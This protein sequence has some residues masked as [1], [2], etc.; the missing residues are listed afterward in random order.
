M[1]LW[2]QDSLVLFNTLCQSLEFSFDGFQDTSRHFPKPCVALASGQPGFIRA[3]C[4]SMEFSFA[5]FQD[6]NWY[7]PKPGEA[8]APEQPC[9]I[10]C[11]MPKPGIQLRRIPGHKPVFTK[12]LCCFGTGTAL[13]YMLSYAKARNS[14]SP[15]SR[16]QAG[17]SQSPVRLWHR[18]SLVLFNTLCQ[19]LEFTFAEF[20][21]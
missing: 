18:N 7:F 20:R 15:D 10:F 8:L 12:A 13:S 2:H 16:P 21:N 14:A 19:S 9:L 5:G 4:Q 11:L 1:L 3:L 6:T 17:I